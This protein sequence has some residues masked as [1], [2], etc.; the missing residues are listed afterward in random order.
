MKCFTRKGDLVI[1]YLGYLFIRFY[2]LSEE[3][4]DDAMH[5]SLMLVKVDLYLIYLCL[6]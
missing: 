1:H 6:I 5:L 4:E 3:R 2:Q